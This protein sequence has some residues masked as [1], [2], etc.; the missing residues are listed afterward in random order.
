MK[1]RILTELDAYSHGA[2]GFH[3]ITQIIAIINLVHDET[4]NK[5]I[6]M[7]NLIQ[8]TFHNS[9]REFCSNM[10]AR[11]LTELEVYRTGTRAGRR[12]GANRHRGL[13]ASVGIVN[14]SVLVVLLP[15]FE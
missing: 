6:Q 1:A 10:K 7:S 2:I 14:R 3:F 8:F 12:P 13:R 11:I 5:E 9:N 15:K 4:R